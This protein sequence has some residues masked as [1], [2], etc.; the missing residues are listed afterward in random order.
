MKD[1]VRAVGSIDMTRIVEI[2]RKLRPFKGIVN[3]VLPRV[4]SKI[5]P[6]IVKAFFLARVER[7]SSGDALLLIP[8]REG[9]ESFVL[10]KGYQ[11]GRINAKTVFEKATAL[12][13]EME[14]GKLLPDPNQ[15]IS[16]GLTVPFTLEGRG[17]ES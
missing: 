9:M 13:E 15:I 14:L 5:A 3:A 4:I 12:Y 8:R 16:S 7:M 11:Y 2:L 6:R 10:L 17:V 1:R